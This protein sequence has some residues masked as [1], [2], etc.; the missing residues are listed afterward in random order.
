MFLLAPTELST[1]AW[2][3][4]EYEYEYEYE[5]EYAPGEA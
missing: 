1:S 3:E 5:H 2:V 4:H